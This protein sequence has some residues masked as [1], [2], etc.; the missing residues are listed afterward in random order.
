MDKRA[1]SEFMTDS[2]ILVRGYSRSGGTLLVTML[3]AHPDVAMSY[4]LYPHLLKIENDDDAILRNLARRIGEAPDLRSAGR[5]LERS[6]F[7][8]FI[9]RCARGG[10]DNID[11]AKLLEQHLD[12]RMGFATD[13]GRL[14]FMQRC[15]VM[16]M[17]R[18]GKKQ[19]GLKCS[20]SYEI[21]TELWPS[22]RF[23]NVIRDGRDVLASQLLTGS[24]RNSPEEV[25]AGWS[26]THLRFRRLVERGVIRGHEVRYEEL[27]TNTEETTAEICAFLGLDYEPVMIRHHEKDLT[28]FGAQ[29]LSGARVARPVDESS[30]GRWKQDLSGDQV[31]R[32]LSTA[33]DAMTQLGY[34]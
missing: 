29:H 28:I 34:T 20:S 11:I 14:R 19:W 32:F 22:A 4:E 8:T 3:D 25:G 18:E 23:L 15:C 33:S 21:Y 26:Q 1:D 16:K 30:V 5:S 2:P 7:R 9:L 17:H 24:F 31:E 13:E 12:D 10:L 6:P 27:V